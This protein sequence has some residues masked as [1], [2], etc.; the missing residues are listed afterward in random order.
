PTCSTLEA[1]YTRDGCA[2][3]VYPAEG[4]L[5]YHL[6]GPA[7]GE[8]AARI[9]EGVR[10]LAD[11]VLAELRQS[12][13]AAHVYLGPA[14]LI[15]Y[16]YDG[17]FQQQRPDVVVAPATTDEVARVLALANEHG[18]P[19]VPRGAASGLAGGTIPLAGGIV[20]NLARMD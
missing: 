18:I 10:M 13:G 9:V 5:A 6:S 14:E 20:L 16:S 1:R 2:G 11:P 12:V 4:R 19:V 15:A 17:T 8:L 7:R 3:R